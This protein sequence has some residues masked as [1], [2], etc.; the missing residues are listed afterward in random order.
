MEV[1]RTFDLLERYQEKFPKEDALAAKNNGT[2][3]TFSTNDYIRQSNLFSYGLLALGLKKGDVI[4][5]VSNNRPEWNF[6]DM[7]M[8]Q[9]GVVHLPIYPTISTD[10]YRYILKHAAPKLL[11]VSD[12]ALYNKLSPLAKEVKSI[13]DVYTF[14]EMENAKH[15]TEITKLGEE[16]EENFR[17]QLVETKKDIDPKELATLIYTSGT[18]G[19]PKGVML[20]HENLVSNFTTHAHIHPFGP[21]ARTVSFLPISH[22]FER[23]INYHY[24]YKGIS[25]YYAENMGTI[26]DNMQEVKPQVFI[27]VP[28]VLEKAYDR[29]VAKGKDLPKLKKRIFFWA[30]NL[31]HEYKL[32][33]QSTWYKTQLKLADKLIFSK[34]REAFGGNVKVVVSG[35]AALQSRLSKVFWAAGIPV[36]E[37]YGLTE[38][39][40]VIAASNFV[41]GEIKFG[42][43]GPILPNVQVKIAGDNEILCKG[44]NVMM[45]YY[46]E[47]G[48]TQEVIDEDGWF[49][50]GD[51]GRIVEDKY[52][53]ITDRKKEMFKLASGKYIAPQV[54]EN[55]MKESFFI[56]Q[57]MV[58]G[59]NEKFASALISPNFN[60]LHDWCSRHKIHYRDNEELIELPEVIARFQKEINQINATLGQTEHIKRFRLVHEEWSPQTGEL[61]PT[62]KLKR[63]VIY[64]NYDD[65]IKEI[66]SQLRKGE[67]GIL[68]K[69][70]NNIKNGIK[71]GMRGLRSIVI[72]KL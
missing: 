54:I 16:K 43:V 41:T 44:P 46:K 63:S 15:W 24:Q 30:V 67:K 5:T 21:E 33:G 3:Q 7:G 60:F 11:I 48:L 72:R 49:H 10:D 12:V 68:P 27:T 53:Q 58:I 64:E 45:G 22:V 28:R 31:G 40:P 32:E 17:D 71:S 42:T 61:S 47:P 52:L 23:C 25:I 13:K 50:T 65:L 59:E 69:I 56:E 29:I 1:R 19:S 35:G 57:A 20:S 62:L 8:S 66:Y 4:A 70:T 36:G 55:K 37:G 51:V 38:T 14:N 2:W 9:A 18:T 34:W 39:S 26:I 6:A